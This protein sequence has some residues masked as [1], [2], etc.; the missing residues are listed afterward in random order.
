MPHLSARGHSFF[1]ITSWQPFAHVKWEVHA[2]SHFSILACLS[3]QLSGMI[4]LR[5]FP[6]TFQPWPRSSSEQN[7]MWK[8]TDVS[9]KAPSHWKWL[10]ESVLRFSNFSSI[11][12]FQLLKF[13]NDDYFRVRLVYNRSHTVKKTTVYSEIV[14]T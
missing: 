8:I 3:I 4:A 10:W 14:V 13:E 7:K 6:W 1:L 9:E 5:L 12:N 2:P 11:S